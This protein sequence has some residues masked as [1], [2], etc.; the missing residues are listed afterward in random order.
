MS[1]AQDPKVSFLMTA[2][3]R[4][5]TLMLYLE[6]RSGATPRPIFCVK[7]ALVPSFREEALTHL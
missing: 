4:E 6:F 1:M 2:I 7:F 3:N 5:R